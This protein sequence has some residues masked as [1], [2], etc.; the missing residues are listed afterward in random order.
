MGDLPLQDLAPAPEQG[1]V[2]GV[3]DQ[4]WVIGT[5]SA[6][7]HTGR[8]LSSCRIKGGQMTASD[9][10]Q[11]RPQRFPLPEG[12]HPQMDSGPSPLSNDIRN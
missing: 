10:A 5:R 2:G 11:Q 8:R 7:S 6:N 12:G 3:L 9:H 4:L 1:F